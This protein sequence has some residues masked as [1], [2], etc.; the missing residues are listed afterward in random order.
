MHNPQ[1]TFATSYWRIDDGFGVP[2][3]TVRVQLPFKRAQTNACSLT[4]PNTLELDSLPSNCAVHRTK[5]I[6]GGAKSAF[7]KGLQ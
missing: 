3:L 1:A 2:S 4:Q 5:Q 7:K 6:P